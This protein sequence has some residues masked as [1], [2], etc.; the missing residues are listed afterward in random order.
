MLSYQPRVPLFRKFASPIASPKS[1]FHSSGHRKVAIRNMIR[2]F[3]LPGLCISTPRVSGG[4]GAER[5][6]SIFRK[7]SLGYA[8]SKLPIF[9]D[10]ARSVQP[11]WHLTQDLASKLECPRQYSSG[12][13]GGWF[14]FQLNRRRS[15]RSPT[16]RR[17]SLRDSKRKCECLCGLAENPTNRRSSLRDSVQGT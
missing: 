5:G 3:P 16:S 12:L 10:F 8:F 11:L 4:T 9:P 14:R 13:P 2:Q 15:A 17:S 1:R 6:H 7:K